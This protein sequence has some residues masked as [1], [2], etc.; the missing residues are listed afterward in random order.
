MAVL[1]IDEWKKTKGETQLTPTQA[2]GSPGLLERIGAGYERFRG[3]K[4]G[5]ALDYWMQGLEYIPGGFLTGTRRKAEELAPQVAKDKT[6]FPGA[7]FESLKAGVKHIPTGIKERTDLFEYI[8]EVEDVPEPV[9]YAMAIPVAFSIPAVPIGKI[10]KLTGLTKQ[11]SKVLKGLSELPTPKMLSQYGSKLGELLSYRYGQPQDYAKLAEKALRDIGVS[12]EKA[13]ELAKPISKL[14]AEDQVKLAQML[15]GEIPIMGKL[16]EAAEPIREEFV[17]LGAEAVKEGLLD[18]TTYIKNLKTYF[19]RLYE[20]FEKGDKVSGFDFKPL[21]IGMGRF[22]KRKDIP[23]DIRKIMGEIEEA[24]Y[25]TAK[26]L[27]DLG[28]AVTRSKFFRAVSENAEWVSKTAKE[29]FEKLPDNKRLGELSGKYVINPVFNDIQ[30]WIK[31]KDPV[32]KMLNKATAYWKYGKVVANPATHARNVMSN[33]VL[34]DT[35]GGLSPTRVDV[36][37]DALT[38]LAKK[39]GD[40]KEAKEIGLLGRTTFYYN[41]IQEMFTNVNEGKGII[42]GIKKTADKLGRVYSAEE[43]WMKLAVF[44]HHKSLG[45]TAEEAAKIAEDALFNYGK[46]PPFIDALRKSVLGIPFLT[47]SYKAMPAL[48]KAFMNQPTKFANYQ[49]LF[50]GIE[51]LSDKREK[52]TE[53]KVLPD[54]M[55]GLDKKFLKL[56]IKDK[57]G[58][59]QYLDLSYILPW[60][61]L[62]GQGPMKHPITSTLADLQKNKDYFGKEIYSELDTTEERWGKIAAYVW[63]QATPP[64]TPGG[65]SAEKLEEAVRGVPDYRGRQRS[66]PATIF[67]VFLGL[68]TTP[69]DVGEQQYWRKKESKEKIDK[70]KQELKKFM[71]K[72]GI[73]GEEKSKKTRETQEKIMKFMRGGI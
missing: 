18:E 56:P 4:V 28:Q 11:G 67:D 62:A 42:K 71:M 26:G 25:P 24:G 73:S 15:K 55:K 35:I 46:V 23:E 63:K 20:K 17:R 44:K 22:M 70:L 39:S 54:W 19:P 21:R 58:R 61:S 36:Y 9:K 27:A 66:L 65:Y 45:K 59:S 12:G 13:V 10:S 51:S 14:P 72:P 52:E 38:D 29:G 47:F 41:E 31:T 32:E 37:V 7:I 49:R 68:K 60:Y 34:A 48:G 69:I 53:E 30:Q 1:S 43:D 5:G 3:T 57:Y 2:G 64:L 50:K 33:F 8:K 16:G 40:F 6:K